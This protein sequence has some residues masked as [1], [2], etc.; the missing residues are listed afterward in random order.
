MY[1]KNRRLSYIT[2]LASLLLWGCESAPAIGPESDNE[3]EPLIIEGVRLSGYQTAETRAGTPITTAIGISLKK[4]NDTEFTN[5]KYV[6]IPGSHDGLAAHFGPADLNNAIYTNGKAE[7]YGY[8]Y[9]PYQESLPDI[10]IP[11]GVCEYSSEIDI[12]RAYIF[13]ISG[14]QIMFSADPSTP[15]PI[16]LRHLWARLQVTVRLGSNY[17]GT[18]TVE[19]FTV[20]TDKELV[21]M[22]NNMP[23]YDQVQEY[24]KKYSAGNIIASGSSGEFKKTGIN[25]TVSSIVPVEI[26]DLLVTPRITRESMYATVN[27]TEVSMKIN[28]QEYKIT[29]NKT[30]Q[31]MSRLF[32]NDYQ[33]LAITINPGEL[34]ITNVSLQEWTDVTVTPGSGDGNF[35]PQ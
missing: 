3:G 27:I 14:G 5:C 7:C 10:K 11:S 34:G 13:T 1:I 20:K 31:D 16:Y 12:H 15:P 30:L 17:P 18:C 25:K 26:I 6:Y 33:Q 35:Y 29:D 19:E 24:T 2:L 4:P 32:N 21:Q 8:I 23:T 28:G 9:Y 22:D